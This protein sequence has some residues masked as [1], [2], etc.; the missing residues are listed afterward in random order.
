MFFFVLGD[1]DDGHIRIPV[2]Q[3]LQGGKAIETRHHLIEQYQIEALLGKHL[4]SV[5]AVGD[6]R[7]LVATLVEIHVV[8]T[9]QV[10]LVIC[11]KN[12]MAGCFQLRLL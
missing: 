5:F 9:K 10:D 4:Q 7:D 12:L 1:H 11:P 3:L 8:G 2:L 6:W